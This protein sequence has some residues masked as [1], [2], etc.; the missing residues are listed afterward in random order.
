MTSVDGTQM[1]VTC[2][3][4]YIHVFLLLVNTMALLHQSMRRKE[5]LSHFSVLFVVSLF[6]VPPNLV[7][8][9]TP[10]YQLK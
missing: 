3:R 2:L 1:S 9:S 6:L 8:T 10:T 7:W 4:V 5:R